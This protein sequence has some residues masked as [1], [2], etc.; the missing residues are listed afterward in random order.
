MPMRILIGA[1]AL[2]VSSLF[3]APASGVSCGTEPTDTRFD[4]VCGLQRRTVPFDSGWRP[5]GS[6]VLV[7]WTD[8]QMVQRV[9]ILTIRHFIA[10]GG[11]AGQCVQENL[12]YA[13]FRGCQEPGP[14]PESFICPCA[15][16]DVFP[17]RITCFTLAGGEYFAPDC[18]VIG[19]IEPDDLPCLSHITPMQIVTPMELGCCIGQTAFITGWGKTLAPGCCNCALGPARSLHV[20]T[21]SITSIGCGSNGRNGTIS[22]GSSCIQSVS[23]TASAIDHDSGGAVCVELPDESLAVVGINQFSTIAL[24]AAGHHMITASGTEYVCQPCFPLPIP[25]GDM[26]ADGIEELADRII[27]EALEPWSVTPWCPGDMDGDGCAGTTA[28][29]KAIKDDPDEFVFCDENCRG[30]VNRDRFVNST[31]Y[32][33][34]LAYLGTNTSLPC[35]CQTCSHPIE[36]CPWD[37]DYD[38]DVDLDD[39]A[40]ASGNYECSQSSPGCGL[41]G[42][43]CP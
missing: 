3:A 18:E 35:P 11:M 38:G 40:Y 13:W 8:P 5:E 31:D 7:T 37:V 27:L 39:L 1:V 42:P 34:I 20:G 24:I 19:E 23:C 16:E 6:G 12:W 4:A 21:T 17:V 22:L 15:E 36:S 41:T 9:G 29:V 2:L 14:P 43:P 10:S 33:L 30:D 25:C 26:N 28:D 32:D